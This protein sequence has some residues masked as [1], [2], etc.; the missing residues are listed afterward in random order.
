MARPSKNNAEYFSHDRDMRNNL[1]IRAI[2]RKFGNMGYAVWNY[3]LECLTA[4]DR[5]SLPWDDTTRELLAIDFDVTLEELENVVG[6]CVSLGMLSVENGELFSHNHQERLQSVI[7]KRSMRSEAGKK[8]MAARWSKNGGDV[9]TNDN[10]VITNDNN[11]ITND[12][13][14]KVNKIKLNIKEKEK[15][16]E[17]AAPDKSE[18]CAHADD[19]SSVPPT[20]HGSADET[21]P[22]SAAPPPEVKNF[23]KFTRWIATNAPRVAK[24][25][26]PF[27]IS[28][29]VKLKEDYPLAQIQDIILAMHNYEPLLRKSRSA[30][31]TFRNWVKRDNSNSNDT[32]RHSTDTRIG[33]VSEPPEH[34]RSTLRGH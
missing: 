32:N 29:F 24:M 3:L 26:E 5:F 1:K 34:Y 8:G 23:R 25:K 12:N 21:P 11:V 33:Q 15:E 13:K 30:N 22:S 27:T 2:R 10:N 17:I 18:A 31:L 19:D 28:Q 6:Y 16:K 14:I 4:S 9:I 20:G 7:D